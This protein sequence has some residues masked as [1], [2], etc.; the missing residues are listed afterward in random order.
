[1]RRFGDL[2]CRKRGWRG[3]IRC[4]R[5][6][7][8][9]IGAHTLHLGWRAESGEPVQVGELIQVEAEEIVGILIFDRL[10]H[11]MS[12]P[13]HSMADHY[14]GEQPL[15]NPCCYQLANLIPHPPPFPPPPRP[16]PPPPH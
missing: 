13:W 5:R 3:R 6:N 7:P 12:E 1:M 10:V 4:E 16:P 11:Q 14:F 15:L 9:L 2:R 8:D